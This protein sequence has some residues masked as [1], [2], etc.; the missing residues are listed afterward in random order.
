[1]ILAVSYPAITRWEKRQL[2]TS[3][4]WD[5][6]SEMQ[7]APRSNRGSGLSFFLFLFIYFFYF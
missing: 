4:S 2:I 5:P 3:S 6:K 7:E 1:M